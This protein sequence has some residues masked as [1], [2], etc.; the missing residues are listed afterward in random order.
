[1]IAPDY[2]QTLNV[3]PNATA[4]EIKKAYRKLALKYHPDVA[5]EDVGTADKFRNI[6]AAYDVLSNNKTRQAYHYK[7]FY[8][9][10]KEQPIVTAKSIAEKAAD[11]AKFTSAL[12]PYRL[13]HEGLCDQIV[14]LLNIHNLNVLFQSKEAELIKSIILNTLN[15]TQLLPYEMVLSIHETLIKL[16][17]KN[18][19]LIKT[20]H[21]ETLLQKRLH[22]WDKYKFSLAIFI[23]LLLCFIFFLLV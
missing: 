23:A 22:Y 9:D 19:S 12:D 14:Q 7:H 13:D 21:Q 6:K 16:A 15:C 3:S 10:V 8:T 20:I 1:M 18:E 5:G 11:L 2:Y 17:D 4:D